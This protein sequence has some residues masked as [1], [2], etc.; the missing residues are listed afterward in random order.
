MSKI[1]TYLIWIL[2]LFFLTSCGTS[3]VAPKPTPPSTPSAVFSTP[4]PTAAIAPITLAFGGDVHGEAPISQQLRAGKNPLDSV[5]AILTSADIAAVNLETSISSRGTPSVKKYL[6]RSNKTLL[7]NLKSG[8]VDLIN[9]GNNHAMDFGPVAFAD[10]LAAITSSGMVAIGG[11]L[12]KSMAWAPQI[13]SVRG[14]KIAFIGIADINGGRYSVATDNQAGTTYGW[15]EADAITAIAQAKKVASIVVVMV[16][17]G[18]ELAP[19]PSQRSTKLAAAWFK[20]GA[21]VIIGSHPHVQQGATLSNGHF[22]DFSL[23]NFVFYS[24]GGPASE[25]GVE[26]VTIYPDGEVTGWHF[27][28]AL[29]DTRTGAPIVT[30]GSKT[31]LYKEK[32]MS[33]TPGGT[34]CPNSGSIPLTNSTT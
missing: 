19:C 6:F 11:G 26:T 32:K 7:A 34:T 29:I 10:T 33:L 30:T 25:S 12:N 13:M 5:S 9:V 18:V 17:W 14:T 3:A 22:V 27:Y 28:P 31:Q 24:H 4:S 2:P 23:G 21:N 20:A 8:G 1:R 15:H 16:H